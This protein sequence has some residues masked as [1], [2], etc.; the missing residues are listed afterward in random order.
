MNTAMVMEDGDL[1]LPPELSANLNMRPGDSVNVEMDVDGTVR[2]Y[3]K[4]LEITMCVGCYVRHP[5]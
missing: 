3:P 4:V 5:D 2:L 1:R